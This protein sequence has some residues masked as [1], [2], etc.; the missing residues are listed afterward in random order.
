MD[1]THFKERLLA[2]QQELQDEI[3]LFRNAGR[4][5]RSA[6]VEDPIDYVNSTVQRAASFQ[7][8]SIAAQMLS[9]VR[10]ALQRIEDGTYGRCIDCDRAI[11]MRRL[12]AVPWASYCLEDQEKHDREAAQE[13]AS[14]E[15]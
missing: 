5:A 10:A 15:S 6:E 4:E 8:T 13:A 11:E 14:L 3:S 7:E 12:E 1:L 2:R 9:Q